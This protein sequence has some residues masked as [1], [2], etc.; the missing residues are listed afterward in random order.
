MNRIRISHVGHAA[1]DLVVE[2]TFGTDHQQLDLMAEIAQRERILLAE[3]VTAAAARTWGTVTNV[4]DAHAD[5]NVSRLARVSGL[6]Y[7][8]FPRD[9]KP[10]SWFSR[11]RARLYRNSVRAGQKRS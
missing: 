5:P 4:H 7:C 2:R 3:R 10:R 8:S 9:R 6:S 1:S 11:S